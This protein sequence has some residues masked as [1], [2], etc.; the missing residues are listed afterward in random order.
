MPIINNVAVS[1]YKRCVAISASD[2]T[3]IATGPTDAVCFV[4]TGNAVMVD[5]SGNSVTFTGIPAGVIIPAKISRVNAT[6]LTAVMAA[7]YYV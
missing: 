6:G 1:P 4:T 5:D 3:P 2:A 7:L